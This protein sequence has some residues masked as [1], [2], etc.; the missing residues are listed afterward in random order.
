MRLFVLETDSHCV[1]VYILESALITVTSSARLYV[2]FKGERGC[3]SICV[4]KQNMSICVSKQNNKMKKA[5]IPAVSC[6]GNQKPHLHVRKCLAG[7]S[8]PS[9]I[10]KIKV[11]LCCQAHDSAKQISQTSNTGNIEQCN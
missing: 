8:E 7:P 10:P 5:L 1:S 9:A 11:R 3:M 2:S 6:T 4:S